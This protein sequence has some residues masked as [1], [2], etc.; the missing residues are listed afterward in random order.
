MLAYKESMWSRR[1]W[2]ESQEKITK[3]LSDETV[4]VDKL[5]YIDIKLNEMTWKSIEI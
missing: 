5:A 2:E 4:Y 1:N 3:G